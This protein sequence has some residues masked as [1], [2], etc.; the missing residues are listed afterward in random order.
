[1]YRLVLGGI[2][3]F[4]VGF[5]LKSAYIQFIQISSKILSN[6]YVLICS[7]ATIYRYSDIYRDM[8]VYRD[9]I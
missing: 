7:A 5:Y 9:M 1:M 3:V 4:V 2:L 8:E 6:S